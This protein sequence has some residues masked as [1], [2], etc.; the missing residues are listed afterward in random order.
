MSN[1]LT[2]EQKQSIIQLIEDGLSSR[3]IAKEVLG[4]ETAKST[5]NDFINREKP[6]TIG[7]Y[8]DNKGAKVFLGDVE[9]SASVVYTFNRFKAF[10]KPDQVIQEPYM[11]TFAG[12]WLHSPAITSHKLTDYK[13][14]KLD[15]KNDREL[16][17]DLWKILDDCDIFVA[18]NARFDTGWLNQRFAYWGMKPPSPYKVVDTLKEI[19]LAFSLPSNS[20]ASSAN[21]FELPNRK[22]DNAGWSLWQRCM[23]GD[24]SAFLEM[25]TYNIGDITTLEDLYLKVRPWMKNHPNVALYYGDGKMRC[26]KCGS[27]NLILVEGKSYSTL[28]SD[29]DLYYCP[30]SQSYCRGRKNIRDKDSMLNTLIS[31]R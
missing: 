12:K 18:H 7:T 27:D 30:E 3:K 13:S 14:F 16:M 22:L 5:I 11:L 4:R 20:L 17:E 26:P 24:I 6:Q 9:V 23:E 2:E 10:V 25:E 28:L 8:F 21:Y 15:H 31:V 1:R 19:K 29:F